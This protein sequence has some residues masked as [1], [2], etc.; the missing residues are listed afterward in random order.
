MNINK[1][2][3]GLLDDELKAR[4]SDCCD[5]CQRQNRPKFL[6]FFDEYRAKAINAY[7]HSMGIDCYIYG[8]HDNA[9][10]VIVGFF[11]FELYEAD[12]AD[13][14]PLTALTFSF[15]RCDSLSHRDFLG[16]ILA[17]GIRRD[18]IGDILVGEGKCVVF[19]DSSIADYIAEQ[20]DKVGR[21]GVKITYGF[22]ELPQMHSFEQIN[23]I[24]S[25]ARLDCIVAAFIGKSREKA[26]NY[27]L[28]QNVSINHI[29]CTD[30][31][32]H[33]ENNDIISIKG[34]GRFIVLSVDGMTKKGNIKLDAKKYI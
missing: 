23:S 26:K 6:G 4:I 13:I 33:V 25:S 17:L 15:R 19:A 7:V 27:I 30:I 2:I 9:E 3:D 18:K 28:A 1:M 14:F 32:Q 16:S 11:P 24:I 22:D 31:A 12:Y 8:G 21:V 29:V 20:I 10:R 5:I 34:C